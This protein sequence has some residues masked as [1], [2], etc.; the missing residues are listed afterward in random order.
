MMT[1]WLSTKHSCIFCCCI[2]N[3][4][5]QYK[6][7]EAIYIF[8]RYDMLISIKNFDFCPYFTYPIHCFVDSFD[9][10]NELSNLFFGHCVD[11][12]ITYNDKYIPLKC[13]S[14]VWVFNKRKINWIFIVISHSCIVRSKDKRRRLKR[15]TIIVNLLGIDIPMTYNFNNDWIQP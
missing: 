10:L 12:K 5:S 8:K 14:F 11:L 3:K 4:T 9:W 7:I 1:V 15:W 2:D 13:I 6:R